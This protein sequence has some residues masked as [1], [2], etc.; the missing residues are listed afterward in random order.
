MQRAKR[1]RLD[2]A[3]DG[4]TL[5]HVL[6]I[7][8]LLGGSPLGLELAA[9]WV[10]LL[11][12]AEIAAE[13]RKSLDF[14]AAATRDL[15]TR[16]SSLRTTFEYSW[17]LLT[18]SEQ[19]ALRRL[20]V[21]VGGF[22]REAASGV[23]GASIPLLASLV[24]KSLLRVLENGRYDRHPL[25]YSYTREKLAAQPDELEAAKHQHA[26]YFAALAEEAVSA[27]AT[28]AQVAWLAR[29]EAEHDNLR[30]ALEWSLDGAAAE[31][32]LRLAAALYRFWYYRSYF[33]EGRYWLERALSAAARMSPPPT[34]LKVRMLHSAGVLADEQGDYAQAVALY[35]ESL[36]LA[37]TLGDPVREAVSLNSLGVAAWEQ[38]DYAKAQALLEESL[39]LRRRS[40]H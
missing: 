19:A 40:G 39:D 37:R 5:P 26:R 22:T 38:R 12:V 34:A 27:G 24:D 10:R 33:S 3:L 14:L 16:H 18:P 20:S 28:T 17:A 35:E 31:T 36:V 13:I 4:E 2:F 30:A 6:D 7:C 11:P 15:P 23:A 21:F 25:L 1:V 9:P 8:R 32:G 29:L